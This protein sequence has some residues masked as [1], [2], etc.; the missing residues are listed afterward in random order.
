MVNFNGLIPFLCLIIFKCVTFALQEKISSVHSCLNDAKD[1]PNN[2]LNGRTLAG[3]IGFGWD[4]LRSIRTK[5]IFFEAFD[6]C[7]AEP[8]GHYLIPDNIVAVPILKTQ[9][10]KMANFFES[11]EYFKQEVSNVFTASASAGFSFLSA[12]ASFSKISQKT[13]ENFAKYKSSLLQTKLNYEAFTLS[14]DSVGNLAAGFRGRIEEIADAINRK[15]FYR[16]KYLSE[17]II[18]EFGT[19]YI[20][21][22]DIGA[23]VEQKTFIETKSSFSGATSL[24]GIQFAAAVGF[25]NLFNGTGTLSASFSSSQTVS[26]QDIN[27]LT[28]LTKLSYFE[29]QGGPDINTILAG[30]ANFSIDNIVPYRF[31]GDWLYQIVSKENFPSLSYDTLFNIQNLLKNATETYYERNTIQG[32][33]DMNS[34]NFD[35]QVI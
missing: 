23:M 28:N 20:S 1:I 26:T 19:H 10:D 13:K 6:E 31:D 11:F 33:M 2:R 12:S 32:C 7:R 29:S 21:S 24:Q 5:P 4:D 30:K 8:T 22:A 16:A 15:L 34:L 17:V 9:I 18:K 35:F 25:T 27:A 14:Q 3:I